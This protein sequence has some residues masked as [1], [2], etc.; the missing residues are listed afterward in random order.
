MSCGLI[1]FLAFP[2]TSTCLLASLK[3]HVYL[4]CRHSPNILK[5][6]QNCCE[7]QLQWACRTASIISHD[8]HC[9]DEMTDLRPQ[10]GAFIVRF[11]MTRFIWN[12][13]VWQQVVPNIVCRQ[14]CIKA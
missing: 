5:V 7:V 11:E 13:T 4:L 8:V 1:S 10:L 6:F 14:K 9:V 12:G 2:S 3:T